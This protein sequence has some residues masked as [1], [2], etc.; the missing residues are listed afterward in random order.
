VSVI[1]QCVH[2]LIAL[3]I[4]DAHNLTLPDFKEKGVAG[5]YYKAVESVFGQQLAGL[6]N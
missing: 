5:I 3:K 6:Q 2:G 4:D 1:E